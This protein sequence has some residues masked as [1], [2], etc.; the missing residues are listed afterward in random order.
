TQQVL[1]LL[2]I[3]TRQHTR[4]ELQEQL[5]LLDRE[6]FRKIYLN[7]AIEQGWVALTIPDKPTSS[8]QKYYLTEKGKEF[9]LNMK[10]NIIH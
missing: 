2:K 10:K 4:E 3:F 1:S 5:G 6:N 7:P 8:K 9:L